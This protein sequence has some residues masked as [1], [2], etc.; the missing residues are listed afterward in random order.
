MKNTSDRDG[1][2]ERALDYF[3]NGT[4]ETELARRVAYRTESQKPDNQKELHRYLDEE[5]IL[6]LRP[7]AF[8]ARNMTTPCPVAVRSCSQN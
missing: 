8:A 3:D 7:W 4:F 2:I 5:M 1:A 6:P